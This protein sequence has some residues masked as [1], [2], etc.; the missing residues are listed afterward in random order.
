MKITRSAISLNVDDV[1]GSARFAQ[2][3]LGFVQEMADDGFVS[4]SRDDAGFNLI[5][6]RTGLGTF[7]PESIAGSAGMGTLIVFVVDDIE[8]PTFE[9]RAEWTVDELRGYLRTWS[10]TQSWARDH[11]SDP[12]DL[13]VDELQRAYGDR[14][15]IA[16]RWPLQCRAFRRPTGENE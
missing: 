15:R 16:V 8:L 13:V 3:H 12:T 10:A 14:E 5:F 1:E 6:L 7:K 9:A 4:L 11:G 2:E